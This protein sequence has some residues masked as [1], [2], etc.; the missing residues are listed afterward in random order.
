[1]L[2]GINTLKRKNILSNE[3]YNYRYTKVHNEIQRLII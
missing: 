2:S 1:M 3:M